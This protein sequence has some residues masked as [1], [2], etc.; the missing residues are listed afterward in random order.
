MAGYVLRRALWA[1]PV[2]LLTTFLAFALVHALPYEAFR[3]NVKL[4]PSVR[5]NLLRQFGL[6]KSFLG[7]YQDFLSDLLHG[8]LGYSTRQPYASVGHLISSTLPTTMLLGL[9]AF[10]FAAVLGTSL[11]LI[12]A[13]RSNGPIDYVITVVSTLAFAIPSFVI[14]TV[15]VSGKLYLP[16]PIGTIQFDLPYGW[17]TW[18]ERLGPITVLGMSVLPY[19]V[20]LVRASMLESL[21]QEYITTARAKGLPWRRTVVRHALRNSMIPTVTNAGP[22]FAFLLTG[23]F[24]IEQIMIVPG[25]ASEFVDAFRQPLD[26]RMILAT[27][28]LLATLIIVINLA[29]DVIVAWLDPRISHD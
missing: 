19:F 22:L 16:E 5:A 21:Q 24:I 7:Q 6:D 13:L 28:V 2:L 10:T 25:I 17:D 3:D 23:S 29:V 4:A 11:G 1:I 8:N 14:A 26:T 27:T 18:Y 9:L 20:R 15:W 12:S